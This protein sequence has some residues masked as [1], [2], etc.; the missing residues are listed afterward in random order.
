MIRSIAFALVAMLA[1]SALA[2]DSKDAVSGAAKKLADAAN[3]SWTTTMDL[4]ANSQFQPGPT[5]GKIEKDGYAVITS[6]RGN[7][8]TQTVIKG[9]KGAIQT[10]DGWQSAEELAQ[11][12][13]GRGRFMARMVQNFKAPAA[14][15]EDLAS[16]AKD[17]KEADGVYS[18]DL[19]E[20][21]A[22]ALM[23]FGG[24]GGANAPAITGAKGT[25]KFWVKDGALAK[26]QTHV[27]GKRTVNNEERD[28]DITST[29]EI[30]D[31]GSTKVDV[32][33][34]AKKKI[35]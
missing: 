27:Q 29:T 32:P 9:T 6:T 31:V 11:D 16:K 23:T 13:Q 15:A 7:N 21:G 28:I 25:A 4:G 24:R 17:L 30:K 35:G 8:T 2:A 20:E 34:D 14:Q 19:T 33:E 3:Y 10:Q 5:Q 12:T 18:G 1:G 22:K 26:F